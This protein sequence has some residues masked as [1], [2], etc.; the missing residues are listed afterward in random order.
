MLAW[1]MPEIWKSQQRVMGMPNL[2]AGVFVLTGMYHAAGL[3]AGVGRSP[4]LRSYI[5]LDRTRFVT[6]RT[7]RLTLDPDI[8]R[9]IAYRPF[10]FD[11]DPRTHNPVV[12]DRPLSYVL[13]PTFTSAYSLPFSVLLTV[14]LR[15]LHR[16][17]C[18]MSP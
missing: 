5:R 7:I 3:N 12:L 2:H 14:R 6:S 1:C 10:A 18:V 15:S 4:L 11:I 16:P 8:D 17:S 13:A 9:P